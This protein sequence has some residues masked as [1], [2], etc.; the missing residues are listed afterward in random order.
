MGK[1]AVVF[2]GQGAQTPGMGKELFE[3]SPAARAVFEMADAIRPGTARQC[4]E[5]SKEELSV[6]V[7]TQPCL[8]AMDLAAAAA[9]AEA[10]VTAGGAAGFSLGE[11]AGL[12]F[13]GLLTPEQAFSLACR[14]AEEMDRCAK[15]RRGGMLA[16]LRMENET[17][18]RL[19]QTAG[20]VYPVNYNYKGQ[21]VV[22]GSQ[23]GLEEL[24]RLASAQGGKVIPLSVS[25]AFHSPLMEGAAQALEKEMGRYRFGEPVVPL[26]ANATASPYDNPPSLVVR[27]V[28]SPV[29]WQKTIERMLSDGFDTF[30]EAGPGKTL[31]G[32]IK[33]IAPNAAVSNV[34]H[35]ESLAAAVEFAQ[36][37]TAC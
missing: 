28:V 36:R 14:R 23:E 19:C 16:V 13:C 6:T 10:G 37:R 12:A 26:Y 5:G 33:K 34:E 17:V 11:I 15:Q 31:C 30:I 22:A 21:L 8:F 27:Q 2:S 24:A 4:F 1:I 3:T 25:G 32:M 29:L 35:P 7:N 20:T 9:L 18:E